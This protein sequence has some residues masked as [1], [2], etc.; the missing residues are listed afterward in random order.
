M[1]ISAS[2]PLIIKRAMARAF[3]GAGVC[4]LAWQVIAGPI[5]QRLASANASVG[6]QQAEIVAYQESVSTMPETPERVIEQ[7]T[8]RAKAIEERSRQ[9]GDASALY[10]ALASVAKNTG[11]HIERIEPRQSTPSARVGKTAVESTSFGV[12]ITGDF[13]SLVKFV[14]QAESRIGLTRVNGLRVRPTIAQGENGQPGLL[15][16]TIET[17]HYR[18]PRTLEQTV[19]A[20]KDKQAAPGK[21]TRGGDQ[22]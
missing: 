15:A 11:V 12:D 6:S 1:S 17:T 3:V 21:A 14:D 10:D 18:L 9:T 5:H 4:G 8:T 19:K 13:A 22:R 20:A 2:N 16:A 7:A